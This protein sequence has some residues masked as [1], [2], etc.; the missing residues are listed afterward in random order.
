MRDLQFTQDIFLT[1]PRCL[2]GHSLQHRI[3][4][5]LERHINVWQY[6]LRT[7]KR[8]DQSIINVHRVEIHQ[9]DPVKRFQSDQAAA[10]IH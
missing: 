7:G 1:S 8:I 9:P 10:T 6:S 3:T 2:P 4:C 5:V